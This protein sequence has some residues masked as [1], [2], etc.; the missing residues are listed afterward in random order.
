V[1]LRV[2][3]FAVIVSLAGTVSF[4]RTA[5]AGDCVVRGRLSRDSVVVHPKGAEPFRVGL[6]EVPARARL[7]RGGGPVAVDI[8]TPL[9]FRAEAA[10]LW[11][12]VASDTISADGRVQI[13]GGARLVH[14][15]LEGDAVVGWVV[16]D[17]GDFIDGEDKEP[18]EYV[19]PVA[20]RCDALTLGQPDDVED[21]EFPGDV[22]DL[23]EPK[24]ETRRVA[25]RVEPRGDA[26]VLSLMTPLCDNCIYVERMRDLGPWMLVRRWGV[27]VSITGW[28]P[29][30]DWRPAANRYGLEFG[31]GC[32]GDHDHGGWGEGRLGGPPAG[33]YEGPAR[34][35]AGT[36]VFSEP[37]AGEWGVFAVDTPVRVRFILGQPWAEVREIP[38]L[39]GDPPGS[40][41][42]HAHVR[43]DDLAAP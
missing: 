8:E 9:S 15:H 1:R 24:G 5:G 34:V 23:W 3:A 26:A 41:W 13:G 6:S 43:V 19:T 2:A 40:P 14:A 42:L 29:R 31:G 4:T 39:T 38:G 28:V 11:L 30:A 27:R 35:R 10:N 37:P 16:L 25:L 32:S 12:S 18:E 7:T 17:E 22:E 20:V 21:P 36:R 33:L